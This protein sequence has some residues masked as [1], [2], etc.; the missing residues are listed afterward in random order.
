[1]LRRWESFLP[2]KCIVAEH[3]WYIR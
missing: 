1:M 2:G 3:F